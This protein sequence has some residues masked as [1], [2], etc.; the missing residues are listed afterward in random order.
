MG[1]LHKKNI[2]IGILGGTFDPPHEGHLN[3][4][5]VALKKLK[6]NKLIWA[7]TKKNPFKKKTYL[8][9]ETRIKLSKK[10][11]SM[12]KKIFINFFDNKIKSINTYDLLN[13]IKRKNKLAKLYFLIGADNLIKFHKWNNWKKIPKLAKIVI[14]P[15]KN[16][17]SKKNKYIV[18]KTLNKKDLIYV[19]TK[20]MDISSSLIRKFW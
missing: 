9:I 2:K 10:M 11:T 17:L 5:K 18:S 15:R 13:Y 14:F 6:L 12:E 8:K 7:V 19:K 1:R 16:Y 20:K 4:S 3:I